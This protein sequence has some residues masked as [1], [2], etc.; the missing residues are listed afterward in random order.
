[1]HRRQNPSKNRADLMRIMYTRAKLRFRLFLSVISKLFHRAQLQIVRNH[2]FLRKGEEGGS[3]NPLDNKAF[4][5]LH[6]VIFRF[7]RFFERPVS[8]RNQPFA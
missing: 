8:A 1:M 6:I 2:E 3:V 4:I 5:K 7:A